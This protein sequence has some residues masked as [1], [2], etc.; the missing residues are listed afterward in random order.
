M[1]KF[2]FMGAA[3][4]GLSALVGMSAC[5]VTTTQ[6]GFGDADG[7]AKTD[8]AKS[9]AAREGGGGGG[10]DGGGGG[11]G[12]GDGGGGGGGDTAC[13]QMSTSDDCIT[14]CQG[15]H[16]QGSATFVAAV[17]NC[18]CGPTVCQTECSATYCASQPKN[19][20]TACNNCLNSK[21][22]T[23]CQGP[24]SQACSPQPDCVAFNS[25]LGLCENLP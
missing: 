22:Q 12:G 25:C 16:Q 1:K 11:G 4:V 7:G 8:A 9:D 3:L 6:G 18:A 14:C 24:V 19:P 21:L 17:R 13:G 20:D 2:V 10:G 15:N 23:S 5:T